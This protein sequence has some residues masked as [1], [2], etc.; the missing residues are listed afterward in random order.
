MD[1]RFWG[2]S[3]WKLLHLI[4]FDYE[5]STTNAVTYAQFF[6]SLPYILPCK[7]CRASLTE[8]YQ[9]Y[10]FKTYVNLNPDLDLK[11][12]LYNIHNCVNDKLRKQGLNPN[13]DPK[14]S[15]VKKFYEDWLKCDS[16]QY[17]TT[18]WDFLFA[19]AYNHPKES[20]RNSTP[21]PNCPPDVYKCKDKCEKN[22]WN[23]LGIKDRT[24]WFKRFWSCLPVVLPGDLSNKWQQSEKSN[25]P[26]LECRRSTLAWLWRMRCALDTKFKDPYTSVC[27]KI[28]SFSSDCG[29]KKKAI[30]CRK[31]SN[32]GKRSSFSKRSN[33]KRRLNSTIKNTK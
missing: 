19:V 20:S 7:F 30:T 33:Q 14:F 22:K 21:M 16:Q 11:R 26:T 3:G 5:Y 28:A 24:Y 1:T 29:K 18:F 13:K 27:Q 32:L 23:V 15:D 6:E 4:T 12:W 25:P 2:P 17:L 31:R 10:P 8:Y 9:K